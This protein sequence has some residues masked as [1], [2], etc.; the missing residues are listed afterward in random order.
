[1]AQIVCLVHSDLHDESDITALNYI[2]S[3]VITSEDKAISS[4]KHVSEFS[5]KCEVTHKRKSGKVIKMVCKRDTTV[6]PLPY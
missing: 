1:M 3:T 6:R 2:S 4:G 5:G